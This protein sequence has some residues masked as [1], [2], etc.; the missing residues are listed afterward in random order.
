M[1]NGTL[2]ADD[3]ATAR[4][5]IRTTSPKFCREAIDGTPD[6]GTLA[7]LSDDAHLPGSIL[8]NTNRL[9]PIFEFAPAPLPINHGHK[10][11]EG[12][13][14]RL[15]VAVLH[16]DTEPRRMFSLIDAGAW[17]AHF[18]RSWELCP[19]SIA[20]ALLVGG[21]SP[22][23]GVGVAWEGQPC[24]DCGTKRNW[25]SKHLA[26]IARRLAGGIASS[27]VIRIPD[28][29]NVVHNPSILVR[30]DRWEC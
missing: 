23:K 2:I 18:T 27:K 12:G 4:K 19:E 30:D 10:T 6:A 16:P 9:V 7:K 22:K 24:D 25:E 8:A 17:F 20:Q 5:V 14:N 28:M 13:R 1:S 15:R 26:K 21:G 29:R 3:C 11:G